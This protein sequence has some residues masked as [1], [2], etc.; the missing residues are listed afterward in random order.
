[1]TKKLFWQKHAL[2]VT[3][4]FALKSECDESSYLFASSCYYWIHTRLTDLL[5]VTAASWKALICFMLQQAA[6]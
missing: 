6:S 1:M 3:G 5:H 4:I 2:N